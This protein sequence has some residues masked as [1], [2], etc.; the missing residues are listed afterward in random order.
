MGISRRT[1]LISGGVVV[2]AAGAG[3]GLVEAEV[4]PGRRWVNE[5][6]GLDGGAGEI[7]DIASGPITSGT[8]ESNARNKTVGWTLL[9]PPGHEKDPLPVAVYLHGRG[10]SH[11]SVVSAHLD[12]FLAA[13]VAGG[14]PPFA[15]VG[16]DGDETYWHPRT[17]ASGETDDP[18]RMI[19]D[20][21]LPI[22]AEQGLH[23]ERIALAGFSMGSYGSLLL[24]E[25]WG[26]DK[27]V[28]VSAVS[29]AVFA[30]YPSSSDVAF[31]GPEDFA[32]HDLFANLGGLAGIDI[33]LQCGRD[34][35]FHVMTEKLFDAITPR[36]A[37]GISAGGHTDDFANRMAPGQLHFVGEALARA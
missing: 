16:V 35:P 7:P 1:F 14:V 5:K 3:F 30:D 15:V 23:T 8:F 2:V 12:K 9:R 32:S 4:L 6:L 19:S 36:P 17:L 10:G 31:D 34:D 28:A 37:G 20:E 11:A 25:Q 21:V 22:L 13:A 18:G 29:P 24:A 26:A 27:V 33:E